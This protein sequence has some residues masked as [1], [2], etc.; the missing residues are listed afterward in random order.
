MEPELIADYQCVTGE[1]PLW[2]P[3]EQRLYWLDIPKGRI[4]RYD[5]A[6]GQ[7]EQ[8]HEGEAIGGFTIQ[9][10]G[11]LLLFMARGAVKIW[12]N[13]QLTTIIDE[14]PDERNTRFN[15]VIADPVGRVF[16]GTMRAPEHPASLY[17][18]DLDGKLTRVL[19][20]SGTSTGMG[21]TPDRRQMY[22][23]DTPTR[24]ISL[25]DYER[26]TGAITNR[27]VFIHIDDVGRPDGMTVDAE[28]HVWTALWGG[29]CL[30]RVRPDGTEEQRILF[31]AKNVSCPTFGGPDY[32]D[33][34]V[35]TAG[36]D[37][38]AENGPGAG[39]LFRVRPGV[40]GVP[41]FRSRIL[42]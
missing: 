35:T 33:L 38:K 15:D 19:G 22:Y 24:E 28:G 36:G 40:Q 23:T 30:V 1:G 18:L 39:A 2:H 21:F 13:G 32:S 6:T 8:V 9:A 12:R 26:G 25:F 31:P 4:F 3:T 20:D 7:H 14:I 37:N 11:A 29:G 41:E 17:R 34:Y 16:C 27:R 42:L 5:P 10:D